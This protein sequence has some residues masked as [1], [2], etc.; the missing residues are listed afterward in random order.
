MSQR[1]F[2][3]GRAL[4]LLGLFAAVL[5]SL[6][7][8]VA[9]KAVSTAQESTSNVLRG[10]AAYGD[11]RTDRPGVRRLITAGDLPKPY[12]TP[13]VDNGPKVVPQPEGAWPPHKE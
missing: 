1:T 10:Q 2:H 12:S 5:V 4:F 8:S 3:R 11:W 13:S 7:S 6:S 9:Q